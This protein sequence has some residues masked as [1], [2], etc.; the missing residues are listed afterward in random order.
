[1][2]FS[3]TDLFDSKASIIAIASIGRFIGGIVIAIIL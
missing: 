2:F 1:L 3:L